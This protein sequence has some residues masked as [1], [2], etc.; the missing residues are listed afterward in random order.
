MTRLILASASPRRQMLLSQA[1]F[2]FDI[3]PSGVDE[4][5]DE[6]V[7]PYDTVKILSARKAESV[8]ERVY[9]PAVILAADTIVAI[10]GRVLGKPAD[11]A[12]AAAMLRLLQGKTHTVYTGVTLMGGRPGGVETKHIVDNTNVTMRP[13]SEK[14]IQAYVRTG[15]PRDK[16]GG[17]AAQGRGS[18]FIERIEGDYNTVVGLPLVR[19]YLALREM[20]VEPLDTG[21]GQDA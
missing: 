13:L 21:E 12:E 19:V 10:H 4:K 3:L 18:L 11:D 16:A 14:E 6:T 9:E 8:L 7:S 5:L 20:G 1:G 17:Y 2:R 15:E